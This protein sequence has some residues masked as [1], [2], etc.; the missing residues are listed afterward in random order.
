[1]NQAPPPVSDPYRDA[2][3]RRRE[4]F[5]AALIAVVLAGL[6]W[7]ESAFFEFTGQQG[8]GNLMFFA[9][10]N[11]NVILA[12]VLLF[13]ILRNLT[14]L[15]FERRRHV[16]GARL[17]T[18]L[19]V[20]FAAFALVPTSLLFYVAMSFV[21]NSVQRWFSVQIEASLSESM[22]VAQSFYDITESRAITHATE[23]AARLAGSAEFAAWTANAEPQAAPAAASL[24][25]TLAGFHRFLLVE[26]IELYPSPDGPPPIVLS[27]R[28]PPDAVP[29]EVIA[30]VLTGQTASR[31]DTVG[32][33][34]LA[35]G[36]APVTDPRTQKPVA[37]V[38]VG[39]QVP[40]ALLAKLEVI[41]DTHDQYRQLRILRT[42]IQMNYLIYLALISLFIFFSATWFGF[43]LARQITDP[44][45]R[46]AEGAEAVAAGELDVRIDKVADDEI[47]M[48][49]QTF[50]NMLDD[51]SASRQALEQTMTNLEISNV[52]LERRRAS[53]AAVLDHVA[54][55]VISFDGEGR[56]TTLNPSAERILGLSVADAI[57]RSA[58]EAFPAQLAAALATLVRHAEQSSADA[59][60]EQADLN[61]GGQPR[62]V[63]AVY[64]PIQPP[65][66]GPGGSVLVVEDLT[67]LL[68]AQR[69]A[70]W[71]E[72][73]RRI[74]HEIK[75]PLTP[76]QLAAQRLRKRY[77]DRFDPEEDKVFFESTG[78]IVRQVEEMK[79]MVAE[80]SDFARMAESKPSP[81]EIGDIVRETLVLVS[82]AH[83]KIEFDIQV[84]EGIPRL[85]LDRHQIKRALINVLDNAVAAIASRGK[86]SVTARLTPDAGRVRIE[87][88][89][90]G[91][92]L[93]EAYRGRIFEPYFSTKKM[94]TGLGLAIVHRIVHDHGGTV[95]LRDNT[96]HGTIVSITVPIRAA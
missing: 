87:V 96:P 55:G 81:A 1:M 68:S 40:G 67:E 86:I 54:A 19:V 83:K 47:G 20:A 53:M 78:V 69:V 82:E 33:A 42:P 11:V 6:L 50:N 18:R 4:L 66:A 89:D 16:F 3:R 80:F 24:R 51:L 65:P 45:Q 48:L 64:S 71:Q 63:L 61:I 57:G 34:E 77:A 56:I 30:R 41:R 32:D 79:T 44:L 7:A 88:A 52:E 59:V 38:A 58:D 95:T 90:T 43:Y 72:I 60:Q 15:L 85:I 73:A 74:A 10:T 49:V 17:R 70:A 35:R 37:V 26:S 29:I 5:A 92:G 2:R 62:T 14:K 39:F 28:A 12:C 84:D 13:L 21:S 9:L 25:E 23:I 93:P 91:R 75:N 22:A 46:L 31:V 76:I 8:P 36:L 94:G 27:S